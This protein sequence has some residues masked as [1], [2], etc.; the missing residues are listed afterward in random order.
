MRYRIGEIGDPWGMPV[1]VE[2]RSEMPSGI[3]IL[4]LRLDRKASTQGGVVPGVV[5]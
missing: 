3:R 2:N 4:V 1:G 5:F